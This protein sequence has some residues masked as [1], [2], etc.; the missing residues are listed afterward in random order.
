MSY[1]VNIKRD[2]VIKLLR[3]LDPN[4]S[5]NRKSRSS[6]MTAIPISGTNISW[7]TDGYDKLKPY[8]L[9]VH[10]C[11]DGFSRKILWLKILRTKNDPTA[12]AHFY[13]ETV[14]KMGFCP[15]HL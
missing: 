8:G 11:V 10:G 5:E 4:G 9:L 13:I 7:H 14:K 1:R 6:Q 12:V 2:V 15:Q 3:E